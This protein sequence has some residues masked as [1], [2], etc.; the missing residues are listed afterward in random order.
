T[1]AIAELF[2]KVVDAKSTF[3]FQHSLKVAQL[4]KYLAKQLAYSPKMQN[5]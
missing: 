4:S 3:T 2:A 5:M 1:I